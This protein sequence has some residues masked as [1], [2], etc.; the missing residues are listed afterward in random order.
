MVRST[1]LLVL[2]SVLLVGVVQAGHGWGGDNYG[3]NRPPWWNDDNGDN[4]NGNDNNDDNSNN[5][6]QGALFSSEAS[7][8]KATRILIAHAVLASLVWVIFIP[9]FAILLRLN[10]KSPTILKLHA[11]GQV[12][13][14]IIYIAAAG[15]GVWLAQQSAAFGIW[16]D[17]HPRLGLAILAIAFLQPIFGFVHHRIYKKRAQN[18]G[19]GK[20]SQA[21]GRTPVGRI[22]LWIGRILIALGIINGGLGIRL[23]SYSPFQTDATSQ[24]ASIAYGTIAGSMFLLY[25]IFVIAFEIRR[26]RFQLAHEEREREVVPKGTLPTYDESEES[27]GRGSPPSRYQ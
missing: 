12:V 8:N 21:P 19:A 26:A 5:I 2:S 3:G 15:M 11:I 6:N 1:A 20:P 24:K 17:P 16:N 7:F 27:V 25:L 10:L 14:Y 22:H 23:A 9:S 13:S 18:S 4:D